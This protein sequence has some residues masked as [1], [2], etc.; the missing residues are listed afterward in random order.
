MNDCLSI[1]LKTKIMKIFFVVLFGLSSYFSANAQLHPDF[2]STINVFKKKLNQPTR[3]IDLQPLVHADQNNALNNDFVVYLPQ[4]L[5]Q[6]QH[7]VN[8][9]DI[10]Q[11]TPDNIYVVKP[12]NTVSF[13]MPVANPS[14]TKE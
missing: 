9:I 2:D 13:S 12:D 8:G 14:K 3:K 6:F 5:L 4:P 7:N 1:V 10:F 11:A